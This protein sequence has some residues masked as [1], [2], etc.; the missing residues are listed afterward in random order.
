[1][2]KPS[3]AAKAA[4]I[5]YHTYGVQGYESAAA[6]YDTLAKNTAPI[7]DIL[8]AAPGAGIWNPLDSLS[9]YEL[10]ENIEMLALSIDNIFKYYETKEGL[11]KQNS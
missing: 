7:S 5:L 10:W 9:E 6:L 2:P 11:T 4:S 8:E 3:D 1:M